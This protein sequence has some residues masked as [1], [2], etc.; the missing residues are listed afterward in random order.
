[1]RTVFN[2]VQDMGV[3]MSEGDIAH[4]NPTLAKPKRKAKLISFKDPNHGLRFYPDLYILAGPIGIYCPTIKL[5]S[6]SCQKVGQNNQL[7]KM[8]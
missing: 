4:H 5:T 1:M 6:H 3:P 8:I 7:I 2:I